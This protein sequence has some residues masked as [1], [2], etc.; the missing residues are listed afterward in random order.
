[1]PHRTEDQI[2]PEPLSPEI[3]ADHVAIASAAIPVPQA[4]ETRR[5]YAADWDAFVA[6]GRARQ[7]AVL[8][9]Q[10]QTVAA[11]LQALSASLSVGALARRAA[12][13]AD[14][15]RRHN[16]PSPAQ[17][18]SVRR[19]LR[20]A[21]DAKRAALITPSA[22]RARR[23][24]P[25]RPGPAQLL[26]MAARCPG[27]V[28]GLR[29][30][31]LLLLTAAGICGERLLAIDYEHI[32]FTAQGMVLA[33][34]GAAA[35]RGAR[36]VSAAEKAGVLDPV[37]DPAVLAGSASHDAAPFV[38]ARLAVDA[39]CPVRALERWVEHSETRF[40]PVFRKVNRWGGIEHTR[41]R[42]DA[43]RRIWQRCTEALRPVPGKRPSGGPRENTT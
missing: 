35:M 4:A 26:R 22:G 2:L 23:S 25:A 30:R 41:L 24:R 40:G 13:I 39:A 34:P 32:H 5:L 21:R 38:T 11:Y 17:D 36:L 15:H 8:P 6:W 1:M 16:L 12:A 3:A 14:R 19:V 29:D 43:L 37:S 9:A 33:S 31:A 27:D 7:H 10:P 18:A 28:A 20:A 42:P